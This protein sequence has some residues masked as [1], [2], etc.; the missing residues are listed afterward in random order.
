MQFVIFAMHRFY[1]AVMVNWRP[2]FLSC[3]RLTRQA[4]RCRYPALALQGQEGGAVT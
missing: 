4:A 1:E 2:E 3:L